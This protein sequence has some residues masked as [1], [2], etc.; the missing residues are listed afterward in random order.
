MAHI[1]DAGSK[2]AREITLLLVTHDIDEAVFV[3]DRVLVLE[4]QP[5][6]VRDV[7]AVATRRPRDRADATLSALR[8]RVPSALHTVHAI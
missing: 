8:S 3:S 6:K 4:S 5:G 2:R 7:I 1:P